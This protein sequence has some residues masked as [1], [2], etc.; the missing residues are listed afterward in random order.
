MSG[1]VVVDDAVNMGDVQASGRHVGRQQHGARLGLEL[2]QSSETLILT[3]RWK[4]RL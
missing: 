4:Q 3:D 2:V 1:D